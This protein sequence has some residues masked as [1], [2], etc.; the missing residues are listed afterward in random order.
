MLHDNHMSYL[1]RRAAAVLLQ[2]AEHPDGGWA[3]REEPAAVVHMAALALHATAAE[4]A[5]QHHTSLLAVL[6]RTGIRS[7]ATDTCHRTAVHP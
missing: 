4:L 5:H 1:H 6:E 2:L 3:L 7:C